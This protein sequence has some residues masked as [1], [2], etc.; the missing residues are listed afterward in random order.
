MSKRYG[1]LEK[2][3]LTVN[4]VMPNK[5]RFGQIFI[6]TKCNLCCDYCQVTKRTTK[7]VSLDCWEEILERLAKWGVTI[8]SITGGEPLIRKD[9]EDIIVKMRKLRMISRLNTNGTLLTPARIDSLAK[10]GLCSLSLSLDS[11]GDGKKVKS[12]SERVFSLLSAVKQKG[13]VAEVRC[14]LK[15]SDPMEA[16]KLAEETIKRGF[17]F[18]MSLP[19]S[20]GGLF[21][22]PARTSPVIG[23]MA[24]NGRGIWL[25]REVFQ[26]EAGMGGWKC[27][28]AIDAWVTVNNDGTLMPCQ[29]Y[30]SNIKVLEISTLKDASWRKCKSAAIAQCPGCLY[31]CYYDQEFRFSNFFTYLRQEFATLKETGR[32]LF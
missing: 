19:Q 20:V 26:N 29:E 3:L 10:A 23:G 22:R 27:N 28:P 18:G 32:A 12:D 16:P 1:Y 31:S 14:T 2:M 6:T 13:I 15:L 9:L 24:Q 30:G 21:S 7:D 17:F 4:Q 5:G 25:P 8:V 11:L